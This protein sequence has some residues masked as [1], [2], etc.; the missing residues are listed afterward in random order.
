MSLY[1]NRGNIDNANYTYIMLGVVTKDT[2]VI[3]YHWGISLKREKFSN[4]AEHYRTSFPCT[5]NNRI[6]KAFNNWK[7]DVIY[8]K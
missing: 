4:Y 6:V 8:A 2:S 5:V 1:S 3:S 7:R